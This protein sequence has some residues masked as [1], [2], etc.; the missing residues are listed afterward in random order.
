MGEQFPRELRRR[1][2]R[3]LNYSELEMEKLYIEDFSIVPDQKYNQSLQPDYQV[4]YWN[5]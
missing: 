5:L 2:M 3:N 1:N 4:G